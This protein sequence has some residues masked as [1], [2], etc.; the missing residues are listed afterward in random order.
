MTDFVS[1]LAGVLLIVA[2]TFEILQGAAAIANDDLYASS[3]E[4]LF[5]FDLTVWGWVHVVIGVLCFIV[6]VGILRNASWAQI[7]GIIVAGLSAMANF[8]FLPYYPIWAIIVIAINVLIIYA[9]S[10][11]LKD[12]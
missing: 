7:S 4:Y 10:T 2:A 12:G 11:K 6:A 8:A 1:T 5:R 3:S 9:L